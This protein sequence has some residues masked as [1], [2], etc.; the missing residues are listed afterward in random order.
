VFGPGLGEP[1]GFQV[2]AKLIEFVAI[3]ARQQDGAGAETVT[4]GVHADSRFANK[5]SNRRQNVMLRD[6]QHL[7]PMRTL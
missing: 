7:H 6:A 5:R 3:L 4:E 2:V 1:F